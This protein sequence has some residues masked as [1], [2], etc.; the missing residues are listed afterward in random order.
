M[1]K[2]DCEVKNSKG[3]I[4]KTTIEAESIQKLA[5]LLSE[6][7]FYLVKATAAKEGGGFGGFFGG[8]VSSKELMVFTVQLSTLVGSA[9]PLVE[10]IGI[11]MDQTENPYFKSVL[12]KIGKDLQSGQTFSSSLRKFPKVFNHIFCNMVEAGEAGGMLDSVLKR[13]ASFA[14]ADSKMRGK[15]K[16]ALTMPVVQLV[17]AIGCVVFLLVKIFPNFTKMFKKMKADLPGITKFLIF[18]SDSL[19]ENWMMWLIGTAGVGVGGYLFLQTDLGESLMNHIAVRAPI[20]GNLTK[21]VAV[22]RFC[23]TFCSL[24]AAG[25]PILNALKITASVMGNKLFE[26]MIMEMAVGVQQGKRLAATIKGN[27]LFPTMVQK[28]IEVGENSG[29]LDKMLEKAADFFDQEVAEALDGLTSA[30]TPIL[31]VVMGII[32]GGI[33]LSVFM[34]LFSIVQQMK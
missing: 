15:V 9:I 34:P 5:S 8:S 13:L 29:N 14:E 3:E 33:A 12:E 19:I 7:G 22:S 26:N 1:P 11:M 18:L 27:P 20:V 25:V 17:L 16:S 4:L 6:K 24:L 30:L 31:T 21:K 2:Y 10:A 23:R 28:M 32:I